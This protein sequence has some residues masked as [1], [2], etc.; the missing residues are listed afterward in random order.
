MDPVPLLPPLNSSPTALLF[1][2]YSGLQHIKFIP[3][4]GPLHLLFPHACKSFP[5]GPCIA[6]SPHHA[7]QT[8]PPQRDLP[9]PPPTT[10]LNTINLV[11]IFSKALS[12]IWTYMF[13]VYAPHEEGNLLLPTALGT[14]C[15][16][17]GVY[18]DRGE[19]LNLCFLLLSGLWG[20][21]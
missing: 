14:A 15:S 7:G 12:M 16:Y 20:Q 3:T 1:P 11:F 6:S 21:M 17:A 5:Q 13:F 4:S 18:A 9:R 10:I 2:L 8:S 19:S